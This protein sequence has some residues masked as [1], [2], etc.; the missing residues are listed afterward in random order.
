MNFHMQKN[1]INL[2]YS[3][4]KLNFKYI[5]DLK[6]KSETPLKKS[7]KNYF[8]TFALEEYFWIWNQ[9]IGNKPKNKSR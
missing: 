4:V 9:N 3:I 2:S 1:K 7:T 5:K 6:A 8:L